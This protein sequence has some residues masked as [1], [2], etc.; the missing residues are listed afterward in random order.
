[1]NTLDEGT[2]ESEAGSSED[3]EVREDDRK[4]WTGGMSDTFGKYRSWMDDERENEEGGE[5][6]DV[7]GPATTTKKE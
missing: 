1:M 7:R 6:M 5:N 2:G 3:S 4:K